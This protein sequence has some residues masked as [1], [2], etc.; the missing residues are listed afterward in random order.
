MIY[1]RDPFCSDILSSIQMAGDVSKCDCQ[2]CNK[3]TLC[4]IALECE[5]MPPKAKAENAPNIIYRILQCL[6]YVNFLHE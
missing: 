6:V 5:I 1:F 2:R 3:V 4:R